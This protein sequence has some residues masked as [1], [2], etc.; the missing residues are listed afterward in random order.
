MRRKLAW[1]D[2][3]NEQ[4]RWVSR[5]QFQSWFNELAGRPTHLLDGTI[6]SFVE[7]LGFMRRS[8]A[9][10]HFSEPVDLLWLDTQLKTVSLGLLHHQGAQEGTDSRMPRFR[11]RVKGMIDSDLL[12]AVK[13]TL[14]IQFAQYVGD[15]LDGEA[16]PTVSRCEGLIRTTAEIVLAV[17]AHYPEEMERR[18]REEIAALSGQAPGVPDIQRCHNLCTGNGKTHFCSDACRFATQQLAQQVTTPGDLNA[19]QQRRYRRR[20]K[21]AETL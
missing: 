8:V 9:N 2:V 6:E 5:A 21:Q 4:T 17:D 1:V 12:R 3:L 15:T 16:S 14:L 20:Q 19:K 11:A 7:A 18:W 13:D 10:L